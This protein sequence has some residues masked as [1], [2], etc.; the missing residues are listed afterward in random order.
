MTVRPTA[1]LRTVLVLALAAGIGLVPALAQKSINDRN[2]TNTLRLKSDSEAPSG[3]QEANAIQ[4]SRGYARANY[5]WPYHVGPAFGVSNAADAGVLAT[6]SGWFQLREPLNLPSQLLTANR[7]DAK[8]GVQHQYFVVHFDSVAVTETDLAAMVEATGGAFIESTSPE[9][10]TVRLTHAGHEALSSAFG[11]WTVVPYHA[12]F[13]LDASIGRVALPDPL[14]AL[15][16]VYTLEVALWPGEDAVR[17]AQAVAAIG[18]TVRATGGDALV[19][20]LNRGSLAELAQIEAVKSVHESLPR[21][22]YGEETTTTMQTGNYNAG[23]TPFHDAGVDGGGGGSPIT[24]QVLMVLDSGIS[25]DAGDLSHMRTDAGTAC[26]GTI[27]ACGGQGQHRKVLDYKS[28]SIFAGGSGDTSGCDAPAQGGFTHGHVVSATAM[29]NATEVDVAYGGAGWFAFDTLNNPWKLDGVAPRAKVVAY[30]GQQTPVNGSCGDPLLSGIVPG[31]LYS[32]TGAG[33]VRG[34]LGVSY[35][36]FGAR[37]ANFSWG[38]TGNAYSADAQDVDLFLRNKQFA[39][40]FVSAGNNSVDDNSDGLPDAGTLGAPGTTRNGLA[41]GASRNANTVA[42]PEGR[43]AF[44]S[45]GPAVNTT[46]NRIAPQLMAPGGEPGAGAL[47]IASEFTCRSNDNN[48]T[49]P[50]SCDIITGAEGTSFSSPAAA[51][52]ALLVGD[53]FNQGFYPN[54][55]RDTSKSKTISGAL[56]KA[57]L[58]ASAD[59]MSG[60]NLS[61]QIA[62]LNCQRFNNEQGYGRIQLDNAL[63][64]ET[65]PRS[66]SGIVVHDP[67]ASGGGLSNLSL[68]SA[69]GSSATSTAT[70]RV[71]NDTDE[72]RVAVA[73]MDTASASASLRNDLNLQ[74]KSPTGLVYRGNYFV[75]DNN[76]DGTIAAGEDCP[77]FDNLTPNGTED[78]GEW[79]LPVCANSKVQGQSLAVNL[80]DNANPTEAIFLSPDPDGDTLSDEGTCTAGSSKNANGPCNNNLDCRTTPA[81]VGACQNPEGYRQT[82]LGEWTITIASPAGITG[83]T[84]S[85]AVAISGGVC[86]G[87]SVRFDL[88]GY[89]CNQDAIIT[90]T[91][92]AETGA[93][94]D[95]SPSTTDV[96]NRTTVEVLDSNAVVVD[97]ESGLTFAQDLPGELIFT[98]SPILMS[99]GTA[100]DP[101]NGVLDVRNGDTLRVKYTDKNVT[102][103]ALS[104]L[105][106]NIASIDCEVDIG[107]GNIVFAQFGQ[108]TNTFVQGG[109]ERNARNKFEFGF[110][111]RY[112]DAGEAI[113][114]NFGFN[115]NEAVDL[116][117]VVAELRCVNVDAD[118]PK[119]C[120]PSGA[121]C[122]IG[123]DPKRLN[124][125]A[126]QWMTILDS[127]RVI[128]FVPAGSAIAANFSIQMA[129][130]GPGQAFEDTGSGQ[131]TPTVEMLLEVSAGVSGLTTE[132]LAIFRQRLNVDELSTMYSTDFPSGGSE[133]VDQG[134]GTAGNNNEIAEN[135]ITEFSNYQGNDYRFETFNYGSLIATGKNL[136]LMSPWNFDGDN[137]GMINGLAGPADA[138]A[139]ASFNIGNWGEDKNF[140]GI[141]DGA[142]SG[143][144]NAGAACYNFPADV[145]CNGGGTCVTAENALGATGGFVNNWN[146]Q[147]GCGWQTKPPSACSAAT[148]RG[149]FDVS[150]CRGTCRVLTNQPISS[151]AAC[152]AGAP[153]LPSCPTVKGCADN[154]NAFDGQTCVTD[155]DCGGVV[156]S[157]Q[158]FGQTCVNDGGGCTSQVG[159]FPNGGVWHTGQIG[160]T[161]AVC[162]GT[163]TS[164]CA[165][166]KIISGVGGVLN[167]WELLATPVMEKVNQGVDP[168]SGLPTHRV[169]FFDMA[170]NA[171]VNLADNNTAYTWEIDTDLATLDPVDLFADSGILNLAF[172]GFGAVANENNPDLT[173]GFGVFAPV[174]QCSG[175]SKNP[176]RRTE[177]C[178]AGS[179][180]AGTGGQATGLSCHFDAECQALDPTSTC[181]GPETCAVTAGGVSVNGDQGNNRQGK[182]SCF[183]EGAGKIPPGALGELGLASPADDDVNNDLKTCSLDTSIPCNST[184]D[185][186]VL[187]LGVCNATGDVAID[188]FVTV[189]G[190][191]RN[192]DIT[193]W[194]GPD[195]RFTTLEDIYGDSG[196]TFQAAIG[197]IDFEGTPTNQSKASYGMAV[198][199]LVIKWREVSLQTDATVCTTGTCA[200]LELA[201]SNVFEG[202]TVL[203]ITA[204]EATPDAANDCDLNGTYEDGDQNCDNDATKDIVVKVDSQAEPTGEIVYLERVGATTRY[205]GTIPVSALSDSPGT[206]FIAQQ[207]D[208]V[209]VATVRYLDNDIDPGAPVEKCPNN[210]N[211]TLEGV[212]VA[213]T[214]IFLGTSCQITFVGTITTDN[215][216]HD[217]FVDSNETASMKLRLINNCG[218]DLHDCTARIS[219]SSPT[220]ACIIDNEISLGTLLDTASIVTTTDSF[221]WRMSS[222]SRAG[223]TDDFPATFNVTVSCDEIDGLSIPQSVSMQLDLD[224]NDLGQTPAAWVEGFDSGT[225]GKFQP[226]NDDFGIPGNSNAEGLINGDGMRCQYN[227]PDWPNS[228]TYGSPEA[229]DCFPGA[230]LAGANAQYWNIDGTGTGS[231]DNGRAWSGT[232]AMYFGLYTPGGAVNLFT[233]PLAVLESASTTAP[234]NLGI[235]APEL[236]FYHQISLI[237]DRALGSIPPLRNGDRGV[238]Q[239]QE[240]N[241]GG[242]PITDWTRLEPFQNAYDEQAVDNYFNCMFD[243]IDDGNTEDDFFNPSDPARREGPSS[244]CFPA[245]T[246]A[247]LGDTDAPFAQS[248]VGN[249]TTPPTAGEDPALN[250]GFGLGTW[251]RTKV[252]LTA[253]KGKRVRLRFLVGGV[254]VSPNE[255]WQQA[256]AFMANDPRDDGWWIDN[257]TVNETLTNPAV[258]QVDNDVVQGCTGNPAVGC[259]VAQDCVNAGTTGPCNQPAPACGATCTIGGLTLAVATT[260]DAGGGALAETLV[261]PGQPIEID[262]SASS[263][264][265]LSG[266]L[267]FRFSISGGAVLRDWSENPIYVDAPLGDVDYQVEMRCS[268]AT[269]CATSAIVDV[270]VNCPSSGLLGGT[271]GQTLQ[272]EA[273]KSTFSWTSSQAFDAFRGPI[274]GVSTYSGSIIVNNGSG[275][276]FTDG[277]CTQAGTPGDG[278]YYVVRKHGEFCNNSGNWSACTTG[279]DDDGDACEIAQDNGREGG[280]P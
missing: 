199:D 280:L 99:G 190:P 170:W 130:D 11:V 147:G 49:N 33:N 249:A 164:A 198:D 2:A 50:V 235:N 145:R 210:V 137:G 87:S 12:A 260:P 223:A 7:L 195:M 233:T 124:N 220:V 166:H 6:T 138:V 236:A 64:L 104:I 127:P 70:F 135:P 68:A 175:A 79:S 51:G 153:A 75:D 229:A 217:T 37:V 34:S 267:Q 186:Q 66:P 266:A 268:S 261:A 157:C 22:P 177:D 255:H 28:T 278:C 272:G 134:P 242:T 191:Y 58:I 156:G 45:V 111:D 85:Y 35:D 63:P 196:N 125:S 17:A 202:Q 238:V 204:I 271:F 219:S 72:L 82:E 263:G 9:M 105:R 279:P 240:A 8:K 52:A 224:L 231:P 251:V 115:S 69:M 126:C 206:L 245:F 18:G 184:K 165:N 152:G 222:A 168:G 169:E 25:L 39:L 10:M 95:S 173:R 13:K 226:N 101:G 155:A 149:C 43:E 208:D 77:P 91:E 117:N 119:D 213:A 32:S 78:G 83:G 120:L 176:C 30:D 144:T 159:T 185:C 218:V 24:H 14:R 133:V 118:S 277:A 167:W 239:L 109:C 189:T 215:G 56:R 163:A 27:V 171:A 88:G 110:P 274:S 123:D 73:W 3:A 122:G 106:T 209:P 243:P 48:Q 174:S 103:G 74:I 128:G 36:D 211:P 31:D 162:N 180:T 212:V 253:Y 201:T 89:S 20:E 100:R 42:S 250:G 16:D 273:D 19:V 181:S 276:S 246:F 232:H 84:Q 65:W 98:S 140:N 187:G 227:D 178:P 57:I 237:D 114:F 21:L 139:A 46:V 4:P 214:N 86:L 132:G 121:G 205:V 193:A 38:S 252:D 244:T 92:L 108:D 179:C 44:S 142:C 148:T 241:S 59:Y 230:S 93:F 90:V 154:G 143:G 62:G 150:D 113:I 40:V 262:A 248:N 203:T 188:E 259:L 141:E 61:C 129:G 29:G 81:A 256:F 54:A 207:G 228:A 96:S 1:V 60:A 247:Y 55:V 136:N 151:F 270:N 53:Y 258:L 182:N 200:V 183:F 265:C 257:V 76:H 97:T 172:G 80:F 67:Q 254:K 26:D 158:N 23:A 102:T 216:D 112:M 225:F 94:P 41:I 192:H 221:L 234:I 264:T 269:A 160:S 107:F 275:T 194:N 71:C 5:V 131:P 116:D 47:G 197:F 15:S 146:T 161:A